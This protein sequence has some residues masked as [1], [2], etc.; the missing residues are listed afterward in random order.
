MMQIRQAAARSLKE[1]QRQVREELILKAAEEVL[2]EKGYY[3]SSIE[4][5]AS[6]VGVAKGTVYLHFPSKEDLVIA[7]FARDM[8]TFVQSIQALLLDKLTAQE[9]LAAMLS[10]LY[11][12]FFSNRTQLLYSIFN[13]ADLRRTFMEKKNCLSEIWQEVASLATSLLEEGKANGE[14]DQ[15]IPTSV[16]LSAFFCLL[17]PRSYERL[18]LGEQ[19]SGDEMVKYLTRIYFGGVAKH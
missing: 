11:S 19:M 18:V 3:E 9:K 17:S 13:S 7:I 10:Y 4:E 1:K 2:M 12:G 16:M 5:I 8:Q 15:E 6:R 14:F